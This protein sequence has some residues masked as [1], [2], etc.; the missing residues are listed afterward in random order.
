[1]MSIEEALEIAEARELSILDAIRFVRNATGAPL[2]DVKRAVAS[3][4]TWNEEHNRNSDV[5]DAA[6]QA[7]NMEEG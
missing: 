4:R 7:L 3:H 6:E 5:H 1:M 2:R